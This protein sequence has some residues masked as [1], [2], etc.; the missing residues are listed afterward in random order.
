MLSLQ[1]HW[2]FLGDFVHGWVLEP[3]LCVLFLLD[4]KFELIVIFVLNEF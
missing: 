2:G 4:V 3:I 1:L